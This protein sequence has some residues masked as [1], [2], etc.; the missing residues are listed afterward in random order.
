[1]VETPRGTFEVFVSGEGAP[2][3]VTHLYSAFNNSGDR[4]ANMFTKH[5]Q[6]FL[7]N[8]KGTGNSP[9]E[10]DKHELSMAEA[11]RDLEAVRE[12]LGIGKWAFA[13]H[14]TGG[15]LG[16]VYAIQAGGSLD[17]LIVVGAAAKNYTDS[18]DS[19]YNR[20]HPLYKRGQELL[21]LLQWGDLTPEERK[22]LSIERTQ[23]S[24]YRPERYHDYFAGP[25]NK[26]FI[27]KRLDYFSRHEMNFNLYDQLPSIATRTLILCGQHDVQCPPCYSIDMHERIP[28]SQL[29]L[30]AE[31]NHYPFL[32]ESEQFSKTVEAFYGIEVK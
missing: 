31:S 13:G 6:V 17:S 32:E 27:A 14:S 15:M 4:F 29:V 22:Q 26:A 25:I 20:E 7:V 11:V 8:L 28:G 21:E 10:V 24:L 30:F 9:Q 3:C 12:T 18:K 1:M 23:Q 19:M 16:V 2:M 5:H